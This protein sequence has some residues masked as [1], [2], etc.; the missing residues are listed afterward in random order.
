MRSLESRQG[1][2]DATDGGEESHVDTKATG[3]EHPR[4]Q[5]EICKCD[6]VTIEV[7]AG[8]L[9]EQNLNAVESMNRHL[10]GSLVLLLVVTNRLRNSPVYHGLNVH[11]SCVGQLAH[12][13]ASLRVLGLERDLR[14]S[15]VQVLNHGDGLGDVMTSPSMTSAGIMPRGWIVRYS[16]VFCSPFSRLI[17]CVL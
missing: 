16:G 8:G 5:S 17:E 6:G 9:D 1:G 7:L 14:A 3:V 12:L 2:V 10:L 4:N 13:G 11:S 15:L